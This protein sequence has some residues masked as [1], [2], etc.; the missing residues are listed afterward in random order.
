MTPL[1]SPVLPFPDSW[2]RAR[3]RIALLVL[4]VAALAG[5]ITLT[6]SGY[7]FEFGYYTGAVLLFGSLFLW[8]LLYSAR[9]RTVL[10]VFCTLALAQAGFIA[11]MGLRFRTENKALQQIMAEMAEQ[12][13]K[14]ETQMGQYKMDYLFEMCSGKRQ[15]SRDELVEVQTRARA[16]KTKEQELGSEVMQSIA[17][18]ES[19]LRAV[20]PGAARDFRR[21]LESSQSESNKIMKLTQDYFTEI[22]QLTGFLIERQ[23]RYR[24]TPEG[25]VFDRNED[26][27]VFEEKVDTVARFQEQLKAL[28]RKAEEAW[29]QTPAAH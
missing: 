20:S 8:F 23:R 11:L 24:V 1:D 22:E 2:T 17:Q 4:H 15:L 9:T 6:P 13:K 28:N 27:Q 7:Y 16:A 14:W 3:T 26:A 29:Q 18:A 25:L 10:L 19:R 5:A 21:G 12:R